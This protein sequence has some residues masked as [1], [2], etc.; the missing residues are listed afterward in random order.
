MS[1][2]LSARQL[3]SASL[4]DDVR[5]ALEESGLPAVESRAGADRERDDRRRRPAIARLEA[6][7]ALGVSLALDDFGTG[8]SSLT[9]IRRL[10][11]D[12][13]K[14]DRSFIQDVGGGSAQTEALTAS[15][16]ELAG[17]LSLSTVAEGIEN[18][19][20]LG[21]CVS[22]AASSA[23]ATTCTSRCVTPNSRRCCATG[24]A[25]PPAPDRSRGPCDG[26]RRER[27]GVGAVGQALR[28]PRAGRSARS[29]TWRRRPGG[30][31][32]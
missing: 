27:S 26:V 13:L 31:G 23:R 17:I 29:S 7:R 10:P 20:Q 30:R 16:L 2:N 19:R 3:Q 18:E 28:P 22:S 32:R 25:S 1:V 15:I 11:V 9:Y 8:Y 4:V 14:I 24:T 5:A 21:G 12:V 6:L